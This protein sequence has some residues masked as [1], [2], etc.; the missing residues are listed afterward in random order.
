MNRNAF[1]A[2][3]QFLEPV[4]SGLII[5]CRQFNQ[6]SLSKEHG[7]GLRWQLSYV[8]LI[9]L[10][11]FLATWEICDDCIYRSPSHLLSIG[12]LPSKHIAA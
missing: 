7:T 8:V 3:V 4:L 1:T 2:G 10:L 6:H 5:F 9:P 11:C 12:T